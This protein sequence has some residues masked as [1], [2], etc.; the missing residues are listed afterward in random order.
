MKILSLGPLPKKPK[1]PTFCK[2]YRCTKCKTRLSYTAEDVK[3]YIGNCDISCC[4]CGHYANICSVYCPLPLK[5][6]LTSQEQGQL[7]SWKK[8]TEAYESLLK[9]HQKAQMARLCELVF[10]LHSTLPAQVVVWIFEHSQPQTV[11][12]AKLRIEAAQNLVNTIRTVK[13]RNTNRPN[14]ISV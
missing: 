14:K 9:A 12:V 4:V 10:V 2:K 13:Q 6:K 8:N 11:T 3:F 5:S 7:F 1:P